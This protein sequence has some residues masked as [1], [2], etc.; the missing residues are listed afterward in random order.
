[1]A[2]TVMRMGVEIRVNAIGL[3]DQEEPSVT[4]LSNGRWVVTRDGF[5]PQGRGVYQQV[6]DGDGTPVFTNSSAQPMERRVNMT[7]PEGSEAQRSSVEAF[8]DGWIVT[9]TQRVAG[10]GED[11][12]VQ[13]FDKDGVPQ[14]R[15]NG[16]LADIRVNQTITEEQEAAQVTILPD[17]WL[18]TWVDTFRHGVFQQRFD[19]NGQALY[20]EGGHA[21]DRRI[22]SITPDIVRGQD[23]AAIDGGSVVVW[24]QQPE[25]H[26]SYEVMMQI[27]DADGRPTFSLDRLIGSASADRLTPPRVEALPGG[28]EFI[29]VWTA[30]DFN[31]TGVFLQK[32]DA[33]G[34]ALTGPLQVNT[35]EAG[36]QNE[37]SIEILDT[38]GWI[39]TFSSGYDVYQRIYDEKGNPQGPESPIWANWLGSEWNQGA[40]AAALGNGR[41]VTAW[42]N[43][44]QGTDEWMGISQRI[45][46]L[47]SPPVLT[48]E[49]EFAFGTDAPEIL[50]VQANGL[51]NNDRIDGGGDSDTLR[52]I[53]MGT[54]DLLA[55]NQLDGIEIITGIRRR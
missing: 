28:D 24:Q 35:I 38:G 44:N 20:Q 53:E 10:S 49:D 34:N 18:V 3:D 37:A 22:T 39:V 11:I 13:R 4:A 31:R 2:F 33:E 42:T 7:A 27:V 19:A 52:M 25:L 9:W 43:W 17:G 21:V 8:R 50:D 30:P 48:F 23:V 26:G 6:Y 51:S 14:L 12:F 46:T 45:T 15:V 47:S 54:L 5:G 29:V 40:E 1:M 32:F 36:F 16:Q 55:P 41:W